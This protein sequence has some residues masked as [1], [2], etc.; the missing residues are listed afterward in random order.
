MKYLNWRKLCVCVCERAHIGDRI[1]RG[2][3]EKGK[4]EEE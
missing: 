4:K 2:E 1:E 3:K